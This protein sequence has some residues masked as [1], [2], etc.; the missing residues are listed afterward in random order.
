MVFSLRRIGR[1]IG[2]KL[3]CFF[4]GQIEH[5]GDIESLIGH[6]QRFAVVTRAFTDIAGHVYVRQ[7]LH[8]NAVLSLTLAGLAAAT[9][10]IETKATWLVATNFAFRHTGKQFADGVEK[11]RIG[12]RIGARRTANWALVDFDD[13]VQV[14][15]SLIPLMFAR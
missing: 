5:L 10:D 8:F 1:D 11:V 15:Q 2:K 4:D 7:E 14:L 12:C 3:E 13:L 6:L 9:F